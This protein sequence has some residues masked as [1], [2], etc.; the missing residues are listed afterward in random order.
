MYPLRVVTSA[1][2]FRNTNR[3]SADADTSGKFSLG[4]LFQFSSVGVCGSVTSNSSE[5]RPHW[6]RF[7][8]R[9]A[10]FASN[11]AL[12]CRQGIQMRYVPG[13]TFQNSAL[14]SAST[15]AYDRMFVAA[16]PA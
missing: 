5:Y 1:A 11:S 15:Y 10:S 8:Y 6:M 14:P 7:A 16:A 12:F 9:S 4:G 2:D 13:V 3:T